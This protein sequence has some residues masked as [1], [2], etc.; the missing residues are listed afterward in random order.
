MEYRALSHV[1]SATHVCNDMFVAHDM[2]VDDMFLAQHILLRKTSFVGT[3]CLCAAIHLYLYICGAIHLVSSSAPLRIADALSFLS[4]PRVYIELALCCNIC[5][6]IGYALRGT[7]GSR[8][9]TATHS[10][11]SSMVSLVWALSPL[12]QPS[13]CVCVH[14]AGKCSKA[15]IWKKIVDEERG[16]KGAGTWEMPALDLG[17]R[18]RIAVCVTR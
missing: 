13:A 18:T 2:F 6:T 8:P 3:R 4:T 5:L 17:P 9:H 15:P 12:S 14:T 16:G 10:I 11:V 1:R 7:A